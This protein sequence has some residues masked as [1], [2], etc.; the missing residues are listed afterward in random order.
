M[1]DGGDAVRPRE[2]GAV[3][4]IGG[5]E[6]HLGH[7]VI[8]R[9]FVR[10]AGG[11][12]ARIAVVPTASRLG[13][14]GTRYCE[15][16]RELGVVAADVV[17]IHGRPDCSDPAVLETL[18]AA[19]GIFLTG[20]N[21]VR[22]SAIL[23]GTAAAR[24][25]LRRN[26]E[27]AAVGGTSAGA[28]FLSEHMIAWGRE[29][30]TPRAGMVSILP[31]L[32]LLGRVII[33]QHFRERDRLGRLLTALACNPD[34]FGFGIDED[35]AVVFHAGDRVEI[36]GRNAV[37]I[38]DAH[39]MTHS[40]MGYVRAGE[41]VSMIGV[42]L[43]VLTHGSTFDLGT[44]EAETPQDVLPAADERTLALADREVDGFNDAEGTRSASPPRAR[45]PTED[46]T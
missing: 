36:V 12:E 13:A 17:P 8:L 5:A 41:A 33:D 43:H 1:S 40:G 7:R 27:G 35:T 15:Q 21:Q 10:L 16:F 3:A 44:R 11:A 22:L 32:G 28:A 31:G 18:E 26:A 20:G 29:G 4:A 14:T 24:V 23:G 2:R 9:R 39:E 42:R 30:A 38:V 25:I 45:A 37:T 6:D 34:N 19:T 46:Q